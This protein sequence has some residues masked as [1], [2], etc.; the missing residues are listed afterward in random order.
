MERRAR[1]ERSQAGPGCVIANAITAL[2]RFAE[3]AYVYTHENHQNISLIA[4]GR[5]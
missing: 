2:I 1:R 5:G 3:D 4:Y